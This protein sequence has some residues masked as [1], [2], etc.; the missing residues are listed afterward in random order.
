MLTISQCICIEM[1]AQTIAKA[2]SELHYD[3][4][5]K[6][7]TSQVMPVQHE[8]SE[9]ENAD[10]RRL[11]DK[12]QAIEKEATIRRTPAQVALMLIGLM[13]AVVVFITNR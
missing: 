3:Q 2:S 10:E 13:V 1:H 5:E 8:E 4:P 12:P 9:N 6:N 7:E 11:S